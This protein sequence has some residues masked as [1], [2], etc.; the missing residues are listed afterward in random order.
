M[1]DN[2]SKSQADAVASDCSHGGDNR[3]GIRPR[4]HDQRFLCDT[5]KDDF[6]VWSR[7]ERDWIP[8]PDCIVTINP[9]I[10]TGSR[11]T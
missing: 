3:V 4:S 5:C 2:E 6:K 1:S 7:A 11:R 9:P 10:N 8:C